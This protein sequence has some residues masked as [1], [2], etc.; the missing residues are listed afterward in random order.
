[1]SVTCG[2]NEAS[3][4]L[5]FSCWAVIVSRPENYQYLT[6]I[7]FSVDKAVKEMLDIGDSSRKL[8][9]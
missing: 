7:D 2:E 8:G 9:Q 1:L 5:A 4:Q 6:V 3:F